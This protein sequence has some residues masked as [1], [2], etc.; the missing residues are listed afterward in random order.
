[1]RLRKACGCIH[2]K[3]TLEQS[4]GAET[5]AV[6]DIGPLTQQT[7]KKQCRYLYRELDYHRMMMGYLAQIF[8]NFIYF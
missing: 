1:M 6:H 5:W 2:V 8:S 3:R 7:A 4:L